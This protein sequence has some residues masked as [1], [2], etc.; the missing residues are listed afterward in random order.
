[1]GAIL[2]KVVPATFS[3]IASLSSM[4]WR[5][6]PKSPKKP[7]PKLQPFAQ[8]EGSCPNFEIGLKKL[9]VVYSTCDVT[10][11]INFIY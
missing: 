3:T 10:M 9:V 4:F 2:S 5:S 11:Y 1:M 7:E 6:D 8:G